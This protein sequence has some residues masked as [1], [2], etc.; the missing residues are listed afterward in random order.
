V[1]GGAGFVGRH[2]VRALTARGVEA[3]AVDR[4]GDVADRVDLDAPDAAA[5]LFARHRPDLVIHLAWYAR[6]DDYLVSRENLRSLAA[7]IALATAAVDAGCARLVA[8]GTCIE[9]PPSGVPHRERD[10]AAPDTLYA[11]CKHAAHG[12]AAQLAAGRT[13]F[14]WARLFHLHGPGEDPR[15]LVPMVAAKLRAGEPAELTGGEQVRDFLRVED[16]AD[17]LVALALSERQGVANV[18]SGAPVPLRELL[19]AVGDAIGRRDLLRF[20]ALPY[21]VGDRMHVAGEPGALRELGW[22]P[23]FGLADGVAYL[24]EAAQ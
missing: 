22:K 11:A 6:P 12:V 16:A 4:T 9:Y 3:V 14:L 13:S 17:A 2:V 8:A 23:R 19:G 24:A 21:R 20:G 7:T 18:C 5:A 1:T 10:P 15:R